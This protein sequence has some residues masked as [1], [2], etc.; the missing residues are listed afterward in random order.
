LPSLH[1]RDDSSF[2]RSCN[3]FAIELIPEEVD[4]DEG[5]EVLTVEDKLLVLSG[6]SCVW[7]VD[8]PIPDFGSETEDEETKTPVLAVE[9]T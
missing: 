3:C 2:I 9:E 7:I 8:I 4:V 5:K 6:P 1:C